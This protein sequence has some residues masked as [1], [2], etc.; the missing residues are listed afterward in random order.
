MSQKYSIDIEPFILSPEINLT[1]EVTAESVNN[2]KPGNA[3]QILNTRAVLSSN[4]GMSSL[5][6]TDRLIK[7]RRELIEEAFLGT[8]PL[9]NDRDI[10]TKQ[11]GQLPNWDRITAAGVELAYDLILTPFR[12]GKT[13]MIAV[14]LQ[15]PG[16]IKASALRE[17]KDSL[18]RT[19]GADLIVEVVAVGEVQWHSAAP[20]APTEFY[21]WGISSSISI[22]TGPAG[23]VTVFL[24]K[25]GAK[26]KSPTHALTAG[27]NLRDGAGYRATNR[28]KV[29]SPAT[30]DVPPAHTHVA[31]VEKVLFRAGRANRNINGP[32]ADLSPHLD[33][34]L[35]T[36][37]RL[38]NR[39]ND[40]P[41]GGSLSGVYHFE[42]EDP[43][44]RDTEV[45]KVRAATRKKRGHVGGAESEVI[46]RTRGGVAIIARGLI[47]IRGIKEPFSGPAD[48]GALVLESKNR[49]AIGLIIAGTPKGQLT[50]D[51]VGVSYALPLEPA[52]TH[53]GMELAI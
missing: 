24:R 47:E 42:G 28:A 3:V 31:H 34:G 45:I 4:S 18:K 15:T 20:I 49:T 7:A 9:M 25:I 2:N 30:Q 1:D 40:L 13:T 48:S 44:P 39:P 8:L 35:M 26:D 50:K 21:D 29:Y 32:E 41:D 52:L 46:F 43:L 14:R 23:T 10:L 6:N 33:L 27:H 38:P 36:I 19:Y 17:I 37:C 22:P 5:W 12:D 51:Y 11:S 53:L 16:R